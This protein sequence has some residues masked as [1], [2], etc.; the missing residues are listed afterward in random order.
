MDM[1]GGIGRNLHNVLG[2]KTSRKIVVIESDDWGTV[3][4]SSK[5]AFDRFLKMGY[6][7]NECVYNKND[8]LESNDDLE[9]LFEVLS[10]VK[11]A[12][13][14]FARVT[15]NTIVAN[16]DFN[17]IRE[18]QFEKYHYEPFVETLK[19]YP[20]H[21]RVFELYQQGIRSGVFVPQFH[22]REHVNIQRWLSALRQGKEDILLAFDENM[23]SVHSEMNPTYLNEYMDVFDGDTTDV[24]ESQR[25][26]LKEGLFLFKKLFGYSS[27]SFIAPCYIW[28]SE[29]ELDL[30]NNGVHY[31][32]GVYTQKEPR[33][34][35][36]FK[37][38]RRYHYQGQ[39]NKLGQRY[40]IRNVFFEPSFNS[41]VDWIADCLKRIE[42]AFKWRKPAIIS[43]HRVNY[44]GHINPL[45]REKNLK[46]LK[47]FLRRITHKWK[48]IE[49]MTTAEL[50][51][52]ID[53]EQTQKISKL[54]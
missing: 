31:L 36:G 50:G 47:E 25:S 45:N 27:T 49:F 41:S 15:A 24:L 53:R 40:L 29:I 8:S 1:R 35:P 48:D 4:L 42:T 34:E 28:S 10:G 20:N 46:M 16:P 37:Y 43:T 38:K 44:I 13:D 23:L 7:V 12:H 19:R 14:N 11:D 3:R 2:W 54:L 18:D 51:A 17:R 33:F 22:G 21:D 26:I 32:Q 5:K 9:L 39:K 30:H 52:V 6:P